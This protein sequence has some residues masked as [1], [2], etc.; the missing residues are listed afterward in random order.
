MRWICEWKC[1]KNEYMLWLQVVASKRATFNKCLAS[2]CL[3]RVRQCQEEEEYTLIMHEQETVR[4]K[5]LC[6]PNVFCIQY[7]SSL[8]LLLSFEYPQYNPHKYLSFDLIWQLQQDA[9]VFNNDAKGWYDRII[10]SIGMLECWQLPSTGGTSS[11]CPTINIILLRTA[12]HIT[13]DQFSSM[14][15]WILLGTLQ[16]SSL[17]SWRF[18]LQ[19]WNKNPP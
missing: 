12:L 3:G 15:D 14:V 18:W 6:L 7:V 5:N 8:G 1:I 13:E 9:S 11:N 2:V 4:N 16:G 19:H 17:P 10:P